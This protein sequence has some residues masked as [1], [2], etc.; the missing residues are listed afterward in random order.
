MSYEGKGP[1]R[2]AMIGSFKDGRL[3]SV[4]NLQAPK[5]LGHDVSKAVRAKLVMIEAANDI[6]ELRVPPGNRLERLKGERK[7]QYSLRVNVRWRLCFV[8]RLGKAE[9]LELVDYH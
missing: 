4:W 7:E 2:G 9:E 1:P 3:E 6:N 5:S 8:W